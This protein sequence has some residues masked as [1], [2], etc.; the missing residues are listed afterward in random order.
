MKPAQLQ[1]AVKH[2][3]GRIKQFSE[4]DGKQSAHKQKETLSN[5]TSPKNKSNGVEDKEV[6]TVDSEESM[7][8]KSTS[9]QKIAREKGVT[10]D[11]LMDI[12]IG[13]DSSEDDDQPSKTK[14][15]QHNQAASN[16][17]PTIDLVRKKK[18]K[19]PEDDDIRNKYIELSASNTPEKGGSSSTQTLTTS[20]SRPPKKKSKNAEKM[21][22]DNKPI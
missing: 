21:A 6:F 10:E 15:K 11:T 7:S 20:T 1:G 19:R 5:L 22:N 17:T 13:K 18:L 14:E 12:E 2:L 3:L 16:S 4:E 8:E 9:G